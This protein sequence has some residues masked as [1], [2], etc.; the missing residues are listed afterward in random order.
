VIYTPSTKA[1]YPFSFLPVPDFRSIATPVIHFYQCGIKDTPR[2]F[3]C[4]QV[5]SPKHEERLFP[6]NINHR[7]IGEK[8]S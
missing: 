5:L 1:K 4:R 7:F 8:G 2:C 6:P 3:S